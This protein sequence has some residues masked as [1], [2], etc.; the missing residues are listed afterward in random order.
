V[1]SRTAVDVFGVFCF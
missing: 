1:R